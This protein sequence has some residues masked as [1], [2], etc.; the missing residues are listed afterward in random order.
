MSAFSVKGLPTVVVY[1]SKGAEAIRYT[2]F[3][4]AEQF[5][6]ALKKVD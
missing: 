1:D 2:D 5:L 3:V 4:E 6:T